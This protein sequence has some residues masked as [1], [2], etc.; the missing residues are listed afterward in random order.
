MDDLERR[1]HRNVLI[2]AFANNGKDCLGCTVEWRGLSASCSCCDINLTEQ[3][4]TTHTR[5]PARV[6]TG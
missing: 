2:V 3:L 4:L 1:A 6:C 5:L